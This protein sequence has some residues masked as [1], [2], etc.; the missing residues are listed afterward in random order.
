MIF[1]YRF[2]VVAH[3]IDTLSTHIYKHCI[4]I[5]RIVVKAHHFPVVY[6]NLL[7][8]MLRRPPVR[9]EWTWAA[10]TISLQVSVPIT[11]CSV[12]Y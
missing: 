7:D 11:A 5:Q 2:S 4:A 6:L 10:S 1:L 9:S 12:S 3:L 8:E